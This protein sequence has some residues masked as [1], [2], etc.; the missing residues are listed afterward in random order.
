M[1][2][3]LIN[4]LRVQG[5]TLYTFTSAA[6]DISKTFTDDDSRF[7]F[8]KFA[9]LDIP[10]VAVPINNLNTIVWE[11]I[12]AT[13]NV[14]PNSSVPSPD[15]NVDN[16]INLAQ[17]F[18]NYVLNLEQLILDGS[19]SLAQSYNPSEVYTTSERIFWKW[20]ASINAIRFRNA[21]P[22]E[23]NAIG[24]ITEEDPSSAYRRVV[25][26]LGDIDIVN[27]VSRGGH[28]YSEVYM[29]V[30]VTHGNTPLVLFKTLSD[31]NYSPSRIWSNGNN[32][33]AGRDTGSV[34]PTGLS[35]IAYY[36]NDINDQYIAQPT[37]GDISNF[38]GFASSDPLSIKPIL[39]SR[40]DG[41]ILDM[42]PSSYRPITDNPEISII[43]EFNSV[44]QSSDFSFNAVLVY[45]DTYSAS[46]P[47][48]RGRNLYGVLILDDFVNEGS[49]ISYIKRF[50]K[51]KPNA[52]TKLNGN[53]YGLKLNV[54]FDTSVDNVGV[55]TIINDYNTFSMDLFIDA[56]TRMQ[57]TADIFLDQVNELANIKSRL[58]SLESYYFT[59]SQLTEISQRISQLEASI[60]NA[61]L[62]FQSSTTLLDLINNN[63]D[64][65][66]LILSGNLSTQLTYNTD[67]LQQGD[68]LILDKS[69]P[70]QVRLINRVQKYSNFMICENDSGFLS[71]SINNG[72]DLNDISTNNIL[73]LDKFTNYFK[74]INQ[75]PDPITGEEVFDDNLIINIRDKN[76][77]WKK[78][79]TLRIVFN[80]PINTNGLNIEIRTDSENQLGNG[81]YGKIVGIISSPM[82]LSN[83]PIFEIICV[84]ENQY[85]FN[86][87]I[88]R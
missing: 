86:I 21:S 44:D 68:G 3:P 6:N 17:S 65:I 43:S 38:S 82:L 60:N 46:T 11:A 50:D 66:N 30:P 72:Q 29:N 25:K 36:D 8:S 28:S 87:D 53:G 64:N 34:H 13:G 27:N 14:F 18:Q 79:Q 73:V 56:S 24:R 67:V 39:K 33:I 77:R 63:A 40:V 80:N 12:G 10:N 59:Q 61:N 4:S 35:L 32:F 71:T 75:D 5:G 22:A 15:I 70:N 84:D 51:F 81:T 42:E 26:Y 88:L 48:V 19:N 83:K 1:P 76:Q 85:I 47:E 78:G 49:G 31:S 54:K 20:M 7:V 2:T 74:Q 58:D 41:L 57:E 37:F 9:L 62:A 69:V 55:E 45:Y 23:S 52:I 16:N